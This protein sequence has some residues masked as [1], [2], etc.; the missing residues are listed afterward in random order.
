[1]NASRGRE[2][3]RESLLIND[4]P[5]AFRQPPGFF[6]NLPQS[7][8][9]TKGHKKHCDSSCRRVFVAVSLAKAA[10][11]VEKA[12]IYHPA[13]VYLRAIKKKV[14]LRK[15]NAISEILLRLAHIRGKE[16]QSTLI[17]LMHTDI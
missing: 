6:F 10:I 3:Y 2:V 8:D 12:Q 4:N 5:A 17:V 9:G 11:S 1:L 7:H 16:K 14:E 13:R 15:K